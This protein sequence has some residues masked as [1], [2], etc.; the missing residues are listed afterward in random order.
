MIGRRRKTEAFGD[1]VQTKPLPP[2]KG[3][4]AFPLITSQIWG[5]LNSKNKKLNPIPILS[6]NLSGGRRIHEI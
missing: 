6:M 2:I 1:T 5:M 3:T 4:A